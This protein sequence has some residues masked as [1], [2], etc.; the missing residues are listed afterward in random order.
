MTNPSAQD[1]ARQTL[2]KTIRFYRDQRGL[3]QRDLADRVGC[4]ASEVDDWERGH[5][6][7]PDTRWG[8]LCKM[9]HRDLAGMRVTWQR[10]CAEETNERE[11]KTFSVRPFA[12]LRDALVKPPTLTVV[13]SAP[14]VPPS[15]A[16]VPGTLHDDGF[17]LRPAYK[18][19]TKLPDGWRTNK[20]MS[21]RQD[22]AIE[23]IALGMRDDEIYKQVRLKFGVG[24]S[25]PVLVELRARVREAQAREHATRKGVSPATTEERLAMPP[26]P[27]SL[28]PTQAADT[29]TIEDAVRLILEVI[30][31]LRSFRVEVNDAGEI[32]VSHT[33]RVEST[34]T[35]KLKR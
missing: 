27:P 9:L 2:G 34:G 15:S 17:D 28:V 20:A 32:D 8:R 31:N 19:V 4:S 6:A 13:P 11:N 33:V 14:P 12:G 35:L 7:P 10:A 25:G 26:P 24:I 22:Y 16:P 29:S 23:L 21:E 1:T 30:P 5:R 18:A 3:T